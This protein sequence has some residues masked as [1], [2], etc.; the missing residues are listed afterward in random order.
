MSNHELDVH[1]RDATA[2]AP[3]SI[4]SSLDAS[5]STR[6]TAHR[7]SDVMTKVIARARVDDDE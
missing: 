4:S 5:P 7:P 3:S 2:R 1:R 6:A